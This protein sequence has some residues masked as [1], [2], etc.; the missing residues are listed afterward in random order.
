MVTRVF[1]SLHTALRSNWLCFYVLSVAMPPKQIARAQLEQLAEAAAKKVSKEL[2]EVVQCEY[3]GQRYGSKSHPKYRVE[4]SEWRVPEGERHS[5][6]LITF[7]FKLAGQPERWHLTE[8][9]SVL[10]DCNVC[11]CFS[12]RVEAAAK[13]CGRQFTSEEM[14]L[15]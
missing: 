14:G 7:A 3:R 15:R 5:R 2:G 13:D 11:R 4:P 8:Q 10:Y 9:E 1:I 12:C 6:T